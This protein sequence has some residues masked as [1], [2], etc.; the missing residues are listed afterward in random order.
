MKSGFFWAFYHFQE[1]MI[2]QYAKIL[3]TKQIIPRHT[4][5]NQKLWVGNSNSL[6]RSARGKP[7]DREVTAHIPWNPGFSLS[8]SWTIRDLRG[9]AVLW[10]SSPALRNDPLIVDDIT[11]CSHTRISMAICALIES[12]LNSLVADAFSLSSTPVFE[13]DL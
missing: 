12:S 1:R 9:R 8:L 5:W 4:L 6:G 13:T 2:L 10:G 3:N 7:F 11:I